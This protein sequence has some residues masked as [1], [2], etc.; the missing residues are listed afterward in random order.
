MRR[1]LRNG[2]CFLLLLA[3]V[4]PLFPSPAAAAEEAFS[5]SLPKT[6]RGYTPCEIRILSPVAGE[7][8]LRLYDAKKNPWRVIRAPVVPGE[9]RLP[10]DGLGEH[11]ERLFAGPYHFD[12]ELTGEDGLIRTATAR[13]KISGTTPTLVYALPSSET[14]YLDGGEEWFAEC[15]VSIECTVA[16][17]VRDESGVLYTR[18]EH[19]GDVDGGG[20]R[21]EWMGSLGR[22]GTIPPGDYTVSFHSLPNPDY[23]FSWPLHVREA[24]PGPEEITVTGPILPERGMSDAEIWDIMMKPSVVLADAGADAD[25]NLYAS[26]TPRSRS[27]ATLGSDTQAMEVLGF[28]GSWVKVRAWS[29]RDGQEAV[30]YVR[31][32]SLTVAAPGTHYGL[33]I[34]KRNQTLTVYQDGEKLAVMPVSTGKPTKRAPSRETPAGAFLTSFRLGASFAQA[35]YRYEYPIRYDGVNMIHGLGYV[36]VGRVRDYSDNLPLLGQKASH[37]CVR[38]S[39]F[40]TEAC[41]L[42]IYWL[43]THLPYHTRVIVLDN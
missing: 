13:F 18:R 2:L 39:P 32:S 23:A 33:L 7:V 16:M 22:K 12:A 5:L 28:E 24:R 17:E 27:V 4:A 3:L 34:D 29:H 31:K 40:V 30:G 21:I 25:M 38:V 11:L 41:P 20:A 26:P 10:W 14:L 35:G 19:F 9:N 15:Y 6:V 8:V 43:W 36:R 42:T 1:L 37:G